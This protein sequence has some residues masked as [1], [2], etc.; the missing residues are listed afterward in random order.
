[1]ADTAGIHFPF[2][3]PDSEIPG[4]QGNGTV[5]Y[6]VLFLG[7]MAFMLSTVLRNGTGLLLP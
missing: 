6:P 2:L 7:M 1:M 4:I 5:M 3:V